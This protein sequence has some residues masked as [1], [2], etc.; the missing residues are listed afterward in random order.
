MYL[1]TLSV[2]KAYLRSQHR[3]NEMAHGSV[4]LYHGCITH[5]KASVGQQTYENHRNNS[6]RHYNCLNKLAFLDYVL[7][8]FTEDGWSL[9]TYVGR[10]LLRV[11]SG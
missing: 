3:Y 7:N 10:V 9:A 5:Y 4:A 11:Q 6:C 1:Q 2:Q 8:H